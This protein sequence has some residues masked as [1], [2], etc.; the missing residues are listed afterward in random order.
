MTT[1]SFNMRAGP[2]RGGLLYRRLRRPGQ[3]RDR[4]HLL[5]LPAPRNRPRHH[6]LPPGRIR[7]TPAD[8]GEPRRTA[9]QSAERFPADFDQREP[10]RASRWNAARSDQAQSRSST[11]QA[12]NRRRTHCNQ[13]AGGGAQRHQTPR[14]AAPSSAVNGHMRVG[15]RHVAGQGLVV[16]LTARDSGHSF[17][18]HRPARC[19]LVAGMYLRTIQRHNK[20]GSTVR[21]VQLAHNHRKG[22][23]TQAEVLLQ[24]GRE[25]ASTWRGC[26]GWS[27]R[28]A[29]TWTAPA[30]RRRPGP[31]A[32]RWWW[33]PPAS[34]GRCGCWRGCGGGSGSPTPW[35]GCWAGAGS[36]RTWSGCCSRWWPTGRSS[37]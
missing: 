24:L 21:Y 18:L 29:A 25:A 5:L 19:G 28:S 3:H 9:A 1:R 2:Q 31:E 34:W 36:P 27:A 32:R 17:S 26:G 7:P 10:G 37:R 12:A 22:K 23:N 8:W 6:L 4:L 15:R 30:R 14:S 33:C 13:T 11:A 35:A 16:A 20:D